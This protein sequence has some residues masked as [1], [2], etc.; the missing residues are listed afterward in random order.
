MQEDLRFTYKDYTVILEGGKQALRES[1][2]EA[3]VHLWLEEFRAKKTAADKELP[4]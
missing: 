4:A 1:L 2:L 3:A